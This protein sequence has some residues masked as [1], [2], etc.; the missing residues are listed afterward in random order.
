MTASTHSHHRA[1]RQS[2]VS[3][4]LSVYGAYAPHFRYRQERIAHA[5]VIAN[6]NRTAASQ[7]WIETLRERIGLALIAWGTRLEG[8]QCS[9]AP[10]PA[11]V[12]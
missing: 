1:D 9:C 7:S 8:H 10:T 5:A 2:V 11:T 6:L 4:D 3:S 12:R